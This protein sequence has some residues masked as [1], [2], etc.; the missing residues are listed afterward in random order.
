MAMAQQQK[1]RFSEAIAHYRE[2]LRLNPGQDRA[3]KI[4]KEIEALE[5]GRR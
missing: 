1:G 2:S 5:T 3:D 4:R